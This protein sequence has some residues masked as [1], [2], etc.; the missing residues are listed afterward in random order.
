LRI[1]ALLVMLSF[2]PVVASPQTPASAATFQ[3]GG[4]AIRVEIF[5][6]ATS[7]RHPAV[8]VLYGGLG[9]TLRPAGYRHYG[10]DLAQHGY[11]AFLVH[12]FDRTGEE[13]LGEA[14]RSRMELWVSTIHDAIGFATRDPK[15]DPKRIGA[16]GFS[17][18][19]GLALEEAAQDRRIKAISEY[20]GGP[21]DDF[22]KHVTHMPPVLILQGDADKG[23]PVSEAYKLQSFLQRV[24]AP[25]EMKIYPGEDH[26][27]DGNGDT[28]AGVDAWQRTLAF[29]DHYL[30]KSP[31]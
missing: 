4:K 22:P 27:F 21:S 23:V 11:T 19:S 7:G 26:V 20:Y 14:D 9:M 13:K 8:L 31:K 1:S 16:V 24:H 28:A 3:S 10:A 25:C 12:Y 18:S 2:L 30:N 29:F 5:Y 15:V 17:L 6:P